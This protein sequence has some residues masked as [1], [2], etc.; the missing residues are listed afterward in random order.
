[1]RIRKKAKDDRLAGV[2]ESLPFEIMPA[3]LQQRLAAGEKL[4]LIDV[5]EPYEHHLSRLEGSEL[6]PMDRIPTQFK[7]LEELAEQATLIMYCHHG[8][9]SARVV[10]WLRGQ[11]IASCQNLAGGIDRWSLEVDPSTPRY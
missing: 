11:G 2:S 10:D 4:F 6:I 7:H 1:M 3:A 9:R 8:I 5:R